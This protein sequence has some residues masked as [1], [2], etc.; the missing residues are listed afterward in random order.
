V[1]GDSD[2]TGTESASESE[3]PESESPA[4]AGGR[5][6]RGVI[7]L[8]GGG[9]QVEGAID[10]GK[11]SDCGRVVARGAPDSE[12]RR[13]PGLRLSRAGSQPGPGPWAG[14]LPGPEAASA[15]R[16]RRRLRLREVGNRWSQWRGA[17]ARRS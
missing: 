2:L 6:V 16:R 13:A 7:Q 17:A 10:E 8:A 1:H 9:E 15:I 5:K 11:R 4:A 14:T 12:R 3:S